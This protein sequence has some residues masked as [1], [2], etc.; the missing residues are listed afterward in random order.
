MKYSNK[1]HEMISQTLSLSRSPIFT[2]KSDRICY[3]LLQKKAD[4]INLDSGKDYRIL[5]SSSDQLYYL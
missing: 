4:I 3:F 1:I 2:I 5:G